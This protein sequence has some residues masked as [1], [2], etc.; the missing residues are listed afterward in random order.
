MLL[1]SV[2]PIC[3]RRGAAPC[4]ACVARLIPCS[5]VA[6]PRGV[7]RAVA[8]LR[9]EGAGRELVARLKYHNARS[10]LD[11]LARGMAAL[12]EDDPL[13]AAVCWVP[14]TTARRRAR[15]FDQAELLAR[16]VARHRGARVLPLLVRGPGP[17]QTGRDARHRA[18]GPALAWQAG[19]RIP[20]G[21]RV[22]VVDDV[23]TTGASIE[24]AARVLASGGAGEIAAVAA[25]HTPPRADRRPSDLRSA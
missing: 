19:A 15:G 4:A 10:A 22:L 12:V 9:Y 2:C 5:R 13:P 25:A 1:G 3:G 23:I 20:A 7:V 6:Q 11:W 21:A 24:A 16:A 8:L 18:E 17:A 14:T